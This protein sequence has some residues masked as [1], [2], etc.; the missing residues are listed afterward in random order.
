MVCLQ[1]SDIAATSRDPAALDALTHF[2]AL[3]D[4]D[5]GQM[6]RVPIQLELMSKPSTFKVT[7][8]FMHLKCRQC[9]P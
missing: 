2:G 8:P 5:Q 9:P 7:S 4:T 6:P 1:S 3:L